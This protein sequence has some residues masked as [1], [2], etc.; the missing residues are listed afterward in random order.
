[1]SS[2]STQSNAAVFRFEERPDGIGVLYFDSPGQKVNTFTHAALHQVD[3]WVNKLAKRTDLKGLILTSGKPGTFIAGADLDE[4]LLGASRRPG[5]GDEVTKL[6]QGIFNRLSELPFPTVAAIDGA[7]MGGGLEIALACDFRLAT[8]NKATQIGLP[9]TKIG[10]IP[11][12]AGTQRLP[13]LIGVSQAVEMITTGEPV[14]GKKAREIG[15]VFDAVPPE[16][17]MDESV[18]LLK[19]AA[20]ATTDSGRAAVGQQQ[21]LDWRQNRKRMQQPV[22]LTEDQANFIFGVAHA[23]VLAKT[24]G[25]YPAPLAALEVIRKTVNGPF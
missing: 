2:Q 21:V 23:M 24:E 14:D 18:R 8:T 15:L 3:E 19:L 12:W 10:I 25:H 20:S 7:A 17:L 11:G 9:E 16:R 5:G 1:M 4:L 13:R 6:G 22:G